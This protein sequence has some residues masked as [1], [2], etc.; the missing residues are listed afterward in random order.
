[1]IVKFNFT[2]SEIS[3]FIILLGSVIGA[4]YVVWEKLLQP[5]TKYGKKRLQKREE[6]QLATMK[7]NVTPIL[8]EALKGI[9]NNLESLEKKISDTMYLNVEQST[10][11]NKLDKKIDENEIDRIRWD[12]LNFASSLRRNIDASEDEFKHIFE[13]HDK[14]IELLKVT[15]RVNGLIDVEFEYIQH[16]FFA[17]FDKN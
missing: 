12:I 8:Q 16:A 10:T 7:Q 1:M 9:T 11:I 3:S 17:K 2:L 4:V 13:L 5:L 14:Y 15:G 6:Q